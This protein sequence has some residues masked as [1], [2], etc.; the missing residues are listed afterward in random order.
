MIKVRVLESALLTTREA[1]EILAEAIDAEP[2]QCIGSRFVLYKKNEKN[3]VIDLENKGEKVRIGLFGG[4][5]NPPHLGH[6][7]AA[8][9]CVRQL[10]RPGC[11]SF[12][13]LCRP[14][15]YAGG[16]RHAPA[17]LEMTEIIARKIPGPRCVIWSCPA[18]GPAIPAI[19]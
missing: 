10:E 8:A 16:Q 13:P 19:R 1:C 6:Q 9:A 14:Q 18:W 7:R 17:R 5:F 15:V 3:P 2:V 4:T 12:P 11:C